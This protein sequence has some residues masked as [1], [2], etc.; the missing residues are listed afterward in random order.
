[1]SN[2]TLLWNKIR[3]GDVVAFKFLY[4]KYVDDLIL[5]GQKLCADH[6]LIQDSIQQLFLYLWENRSRFL[7]PQNTKAYLIRSLRNNLLRSMKKERLFMDTDIE[8]HW[9]E[10]DD[11]NANHEDEKQK[12]RLLKA[13]EQLPPREKE[14]LHLRYYQNI[15]N[16][17]IS[18]IMGIGY[19][20]VSN[21]LQRAVK[22]MG[23]LISEE[24]Q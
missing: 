18:E 6:P 23:A 5:Y 1:M 9:K 4:E 3:Q 8:R 10:V 22:R 15:R 17:E 16:Q 14:I 19:Q 7:P 2:D 24:G 20:S 12:H 21:L 11:V 13:I